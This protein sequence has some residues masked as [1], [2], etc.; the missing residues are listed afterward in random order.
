MGKGGDVF[1]EEWSENSN[2]IGGGGGGD[3]PNSRQGW[4]FYYRL[5]VFVPFIPCFT[6]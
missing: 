6:A 5:L 4:L 3:G 2:G 1:G